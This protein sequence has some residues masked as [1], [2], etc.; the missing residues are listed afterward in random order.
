VEQINWRLTAESS[1]QIVVQVLTMTPREPVAPLAR[2][3]SN[4]RRRH[5]ARCTLT[6]PHHFRAANSQRPRPV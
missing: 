3:M 4:A 6:T 2:K 1:G 5:A